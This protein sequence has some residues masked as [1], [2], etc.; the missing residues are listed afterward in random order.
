MYIN[1]TYFHQ[2]SALFI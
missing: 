1:K 2:L